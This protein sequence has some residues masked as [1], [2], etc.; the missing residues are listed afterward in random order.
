MRSKQVMAYAQVE[1]NPRPVLVKF[2]SLQV[3]G[4]LLTLSFCPQFGMGGVDVFHGLTHHLSHHAAW[5][6]G[7]FCGALFL[8][9]GTILSLLF[10]KKPQWRWVWRHQL[11]M[12]V[13]PVVLGFMLLMFAKTL[14]GF[15]GHHENMSYYVSWIASG[16]L[17]SW[18]VLNLKSKL[19]PA[20][21]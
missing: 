3:L 14:G 19:A 20:W 15:E 16:M 4:A 11:L 8:A 9:T 6:C 5:L 21:I 12:V 10:L 7:A 17:A 18:V 2:Y 1:L 13:P